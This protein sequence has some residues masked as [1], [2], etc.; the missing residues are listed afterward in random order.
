MLWFVPTNVPTSVSRSKITLSA[1]LCCYFAHRGTLKHVLLDV[2]PILWARRWMINVHILEGM[3]RRWCVPPLEKL[4][5]LHTRIF[6]SER[7]RKHSKR[8]QHVWKCRDGARKVGEIGVESWRNMLQL[9][10]SIGNRSVTWLM[11]LSALAICQKLHLQN[12]VLLFHIK[13]QRLWMFNHLQDII[14]S[15]DLENLERSL[16]AGT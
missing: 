2:L 11:S 3:C 14:S 5:W 7:D 13:F 16:Y 10:R 8:Q 1:L 9:Y 6:Q 15:E 12:R 4:C